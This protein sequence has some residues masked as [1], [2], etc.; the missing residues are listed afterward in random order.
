MQLDASTA[1][2]SLLAALASLYM[3][4]HPVVE[5]LVATPQLVVA[6]TYRAGP[7][8]QRTDHRL[9]DGIP[10][11]NVVLLHSPIQCLEQQVRNLNLHAR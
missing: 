7:V 1:H 9:E 6:Q 11:I 3:L 5:E 4:L 8:G 10:I 2:N